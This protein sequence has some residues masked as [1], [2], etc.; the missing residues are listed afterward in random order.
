MKISKTKEKY[1][2]EALRLF[3]EKGYG[4]VGVTEIA[5]AV[6]CTTSALYKHFPN[7]KA[8]FDEILAMGKSDFQYHM[9][10]IHENLFCTEE[11]RDRIIHMSVEKQT[12]MILR[13]F[14]AL[15][16][17]GAPKYFRKLV[18]VEQYEHPEL[19]DIY[20]EGYLEAQ[21]A[22]MESII[23]TWMEKGRVKEE[24]SHLLAVQYISPLFVH[25][26]MCDLDASKREE[27]KDSLRRHIA[28]FNRT[29]GKEN[30]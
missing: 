3:S 5:E 6:G 29:Y 10:S 19:A 2:M 30:S 26:E 8:L 25:V 15:S 24:D 7:K 4:A 13:L 1:L 9:G 12:E 22:S 21:I 28:L 16:E 23:R 18:R 17:D 20:R 27:A 14:D 11:G